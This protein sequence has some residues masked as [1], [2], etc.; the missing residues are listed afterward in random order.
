MHDHWVVFILYNV[1]WRKRITAL[2]VSTP[3]WCRLP[4]S[5]DGLLAE[6]E[7][8]TLGL[9][10]GCIAR[11]VAMLAAKGDHAAPNIVCRCSPHAPCTNEGFSIVPH[12]HRLA[13]DGLARLPV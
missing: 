4:R 10:L 8:W 6:A 5:E 11:H 13:A 9:Q 12:L 7:V 3:L 2:E 1:A